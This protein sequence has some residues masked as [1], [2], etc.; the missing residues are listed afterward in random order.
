VET[1]ICVRDPF[2]RF[3]FKK[4]INEIIIAVCV[5]IIIIIPFL[6]IVMNA[7]LPRTMKHVWVCGP[8]M[9]LGWVDSKTSI[10][11]FPLFL[12]FPCFYCDFL[13]H[14]CASKI[15]MKKMHII[16]ST[17]LVKTVFQ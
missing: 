15:Y 8:F 2:N 9:R 1:E 3:V 14:I 10:S 13:F 12:F 5:I 11:C 7:F 17:F 16:L 4:S 6:M